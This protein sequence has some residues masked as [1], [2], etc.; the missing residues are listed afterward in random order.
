MAFQIK[1]RTAQ[2]SF[3]IRLERDVSAEEAMQLHQIGF[4]VLGLNKNNEARESR[5]LPT[6][7]LHTPN[8]RGGHTVN[9]R[10]ALSAITARSASPTNHRGFNSAQTK[11]GER[12]VD[13]ILLDPY[14]E[15]SCGV[16]LRV[17]SFPPQQHKVDCVRLLR[18]K[19]LMPIKSAMDVMFGNHECPIIEAE[20]ADELITAFRGWGIFVKAERAVR[21]TLDK[22]I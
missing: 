15:P 17:V 7:P 8:S 18:E 12:P 19:T 5:S 22:G 14:R 2:G 16:R 3:N 13:K 20:V 21:A 10:A 4:N 11:L 1:Y 6:I 9:S